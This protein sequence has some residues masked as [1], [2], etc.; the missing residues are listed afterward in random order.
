MLLARAI[1]TVLEQTIPDIAAVKRLGVVAVPAP[2]IPVRHYAEED[3]M[4]LSLISRLEGSLSRAKKIRGLP[5]GRSFGA[6]CLTIVAHQAGRPEAAAS[7][8]SLP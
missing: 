5:T 8:R 4:S 3:R 2:E 7:G 1:G 6:V